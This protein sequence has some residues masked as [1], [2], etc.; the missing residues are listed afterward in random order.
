M[1]SLSDN[2]RLPFIIYHEEHCVEV[3]CTYLQ[4]KVQINEDIIPHKDDGMVYTT[5][6]LNILVKNKGAYRLMRSR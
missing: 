5:P 4:G 1:V 3:L 2:S 6:G